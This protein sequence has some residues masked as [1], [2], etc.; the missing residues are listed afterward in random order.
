M[1]V[2][3]FGDPQRTTTMVCA[4]CDVTWRGCADDECWSCGDSVMVAEATPRKVRYSPAVSD[5]ERLVG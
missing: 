1:P 3:G 2:Q 5:T 4:S